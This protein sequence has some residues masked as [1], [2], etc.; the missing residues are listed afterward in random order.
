MEQKTLNIEIPEGYEIDKEKSSFEKIVFKQKNVSLVLDS[1]EDLKEI[2]G[3]WIDDNSDINENIHAA[4]KFHRNIFP[5]REYAE[6][7]LALAQL[8][9]IRQRCIGNW[10]PDWTNSLQSK[11][12]ITPEKDE[13]CIRILYYSNRP[14]SF[15]TFEIAKEF[16][17]KHETLIQ[18]AKPLI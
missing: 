3:Y 14:L 1:W 8:L 9:Q 16:L 13:I 10:K 7:A 5:T 11:H 4:H 17:K 6:A 12:V 15:P 2:E 18:Q